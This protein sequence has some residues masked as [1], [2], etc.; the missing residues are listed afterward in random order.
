MKR[1]VHLFIASALLLFVTTYAGMAF[2]G[3]SDDAMK[4]MNHGAMTADMDCLDHC[5]AAVVPFTAATSSVAVA[6]VIMV[7]A[8]FLL[9]AGIFS[10]ASAS[11]SL[12]RW[13]EGIGKVLLRQRLASVILRD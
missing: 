6:F 7:A 10:S 8:T 2:F 3:M 11:R 4:T 5:L 1:L 12:H 9:S 13:R